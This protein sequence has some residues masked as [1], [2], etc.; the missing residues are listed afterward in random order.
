MVVDIDTVARRLPV[1]AVANLTDHPRNLGPGSFGEGLLDLWVNLAGKY[2]GV[3]ECTRLN[4]KYDLLRLGIGMRDLT[5]LQ[6]LL[7][8]TIVDD[9]DCSHILHPTGPTTI[10]LYRV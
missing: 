6:Y 8:R 9:V 2:I 3:L 4:V 10:S 7:C 5:N 1:D